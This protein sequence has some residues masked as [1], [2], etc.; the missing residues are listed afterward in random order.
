[1]ATYRSKK[2]RVQ[3]FK[4]VIGGLTPDWFV[5]A[6]EDGYITPAVPDPPFNAWADY[7]M[8]IHTAR[9]VMLADAGDWVVQGVDG[10]IYSCKADLFELLFEL[11][12]MQGLRADLV[13]LDD[14]DR[15]P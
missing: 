1:M 12:P 13:I 14:L 8:L 6:M 7:G 2:Y 3:A 5:K 15:K 10:E 4:L 9:G 11:L